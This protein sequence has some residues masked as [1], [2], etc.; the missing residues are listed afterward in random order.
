MIV[1]PRRE[2]LKVGVK[3]KGKRQ[4]VMEILYYFLVSIIILVRVKP[5]VKMKTKR[6]GEIYF[7]VNGAEGQHGRSCVQ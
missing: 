1:V 5:K 4:R 6:Q 7:T 2:N 3:R